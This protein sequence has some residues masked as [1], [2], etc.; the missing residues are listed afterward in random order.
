MVMIMRNLFSATIVTILFA[1]L[2]SSASEE[3]PSC[4]S[5]H[6]RALPGSCSN[7]YMDFDNLDITRWSIYL[8]F[9]CFRV[10]G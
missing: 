6:H 1:Q 4:A 7:L 2:A 9:S 8:T 3:E 10:F 5:Y